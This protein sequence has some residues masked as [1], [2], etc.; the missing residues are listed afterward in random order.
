MPEVASERLAPKDEGSNQTDKL[1][2]LG[3]CYP[4]TSVPVDPRRHAGHPVENPGQMGMI[5]F[6]VLLAVDVKAPPG[7][8]KR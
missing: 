4:L 7:R 6:S 2:S 3:F 5:W 1:K 8:Q